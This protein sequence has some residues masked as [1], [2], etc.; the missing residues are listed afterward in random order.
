M[1]SA[2]ANWRR[3]P[4]GWRPAEAA[5]AA[6]ARRL[7]RRRRRAGRTSGSTPRTDD[8]TSDR[9]R[10]PSHQPVPGRTSPWPRR[11]TSNGE[12]DRR[13]GQPTPRSMTRWPFSAPLLSALLEHRL[14]EP[15]LQMYP[16]E[17]SAVA[18]NQRALVELRTEVP[19]MRVNDNL[20]RIIACAQPLADQVIE[21]ELLGTGNFDRAILRRGHCDLC[22]RLC[23]IFGCHGLDE[24]MW[25]SNGHPVR[26]FVRDAFDELEELGRVDDRIGHSAV[27]DQHLLRVLRAKV[28]TVWNASGS[29]DRQR[30]VMRHA[31]RSG[32]LQEIACGCGEEV[33][34]GRLFERGR[35]RYVH[36]NGRALKNSSKSLP[37][38][39]VDAGVR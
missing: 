1:L 22:Y 5:T 18:R 26:R 39:R 8:P 36:D 34:D 37:G 15:L 4:G 14:A 31:C 38:E 11:P 6:R 23:D 7:H 28:G 27:L 29:H 32:R 10:S 19:R 33:H 13:G 20:A 16:A 2:T 9:R 12:E 24:H 35:V 21:T 3:H 17:P 25:K 30:H